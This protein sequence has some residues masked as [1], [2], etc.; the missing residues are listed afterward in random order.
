LNLVNPI[1]DGIKNERGL[2]DFRVQLVPASEV[3]DENL[4]RG[5]IY[6][7]PTKSLEFI[8]LEF[9][10]TPTSASFENI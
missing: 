3:Q 1:L 5:K 2:I 8:D 10:I 7:K 9:V 6:L 4:L